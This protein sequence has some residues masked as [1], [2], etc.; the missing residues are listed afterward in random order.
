VGNPSKKG[1]PVTSD[2]ANLF[3]DA[4]DRGLQRMMSLLSSPEVSQV[5]CDRHDRVSFI[6]AHGAK[7]ADRV[8]SSDTQYIAF[9]NHLLTYTDAG[10]KDVTTANTSVI[11]GS[12]RPDRIKLHGSIHICTSEITRGEPSLTVRKQPI[13][14]IT[15]DEMHRQGMM[16]SDMRLFL[17][18]AV[19]GRSN[20]LISGGSGAGKTTLARAL[21]YFID[22]WQRIV[23]CEEI[24]ELHLYDRLQN[25]VSLTTYRSRDTEGRIIR[26]TSLED[27][28]RESLRMRAERV[29]V[30]ET[31]GKEAFALIKACNSG[32]DGSVTTLHADNG[33]S[34]VKQLV[35]Y[36]MESGLPEVPSREQVSQAFNLVVQINRV[37]MERR[38]ITEISY[39]EPVIEGSNQRLSPL[40]LYDNAQDRHAF[41]SPNLPPKLLEQWAKHGVNWDTQPLNH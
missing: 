13:S 35:T 19:R 2:L 1:R 3:Q 20:I 36:V 39:L 26:E 37:R 4:D 32:H 17:E 28:V 41:A 7:R 40:W 21:S 25:V 24:D 23:T 16:S 18:Q 31:R 22:P 38:V 30:G 15:L 10:Y 27:L 9:L 6:D 5:T 12:F 34:A 29:W 11:E 14:L 8:F 33:K